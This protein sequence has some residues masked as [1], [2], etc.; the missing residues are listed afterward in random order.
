[1]AFEFCN[2]I[3]VNM[4]SYVAL[5]SLCCRLGPFTLL[6]LC[7]LVACKMQLMKIPDTK[8]HLMDLGRLFE[9]KGG[10]SCLLV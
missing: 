8:I 3:S 4:D 9:T 10:G 7:R 5:A 1:M 2:S 6:C